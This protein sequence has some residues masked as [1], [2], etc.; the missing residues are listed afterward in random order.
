MKCI[1]F[2]QEDLQA[3]VRFGGLIH[4]FLNRLF[5]PWVV[6]HLMGMIVSLLHLE[7][8]RHRNFFLEVAFI[9]NL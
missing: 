6:S 3:T 1:Y 9:F 2:H 7:S 4:A 5:Q 8:V